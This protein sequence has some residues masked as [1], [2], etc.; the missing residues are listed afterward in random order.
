MK[1][2]INRHTSSRLLL[3]S[4]VILV[5]NY[6]GCKGEAIKLIPYYMI[7]IIYKTIK[8]SHLTKMQ[9][10][11]IQKTLCSKSSSY[12]LTEFW[13]SKSWFHSPFSAVGGNRLSK[14]CCLGGISNFLLPRAWWQEHGGEFWVGRTWVKIHRI[15]AFS[16]NVTPINLNI[17]PTH[18]GI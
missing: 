16:R 4:D 6:H 15:N 14:E 2:P 8:P 1:L 13:W 3:F 17:F 11:Q 18:G 7:G 5:S 9:M 10:I 12:F